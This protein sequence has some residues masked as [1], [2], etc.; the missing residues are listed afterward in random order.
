MSL[1]NW[2]EQRY[3]AIEQLSTVIC[4]LYGDVTFG[5]PNWTGCVSVC[6]LRETEYCEQYDIHKVTFNDFTRPCCTARDRDRDLGGGSDIFFPR[7]Y[8]VFFKYGTSS[9]PLK[10]RRMAEEFWGSWVDQPV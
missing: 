9:G 1:E 4:S 5:S 10:N 3:E 7:T 2:I 8:E 6:S